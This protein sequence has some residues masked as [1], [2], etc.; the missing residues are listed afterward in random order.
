MKKR[1]ESYVHGYSYYLSMYSFFF[2]FFLKMDY[3]SCHSSSSSLLLSFLSPR[4]IFYLRVWVSA[5]DLW[6]KKGVGVSWH[7]DSK[8]YG[9][10]H[11]APYKTRLNGCWGCL[12][13][14]KIPGIV[15]LLQWF[16]DLKRRSTRLSAGKLRVRG[17]NPRKEKKKR[18]SR[19]DPYK[20]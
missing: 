12:E 16:S 20:R 9:V 8:F 15:R 17:S 2:F 4:E 14:F 7:V 10:P 11:G 13:S 5:S 18:H 6:E 1:I 19:N 3:I